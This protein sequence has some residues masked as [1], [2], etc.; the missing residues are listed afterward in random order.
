MAIIPRTNH[1][2]TLENIADLFHHCNQILPNYAVPRFVRIQS[3]MEI[4]STFKQ[5]KVELVKEAFD[6]SKVKNVDLYYANFLN[7][8]YDVL[9]TDIYNTISQGSI[10]L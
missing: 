1:K 5:R 6:P 9:T 8:T 2:V 7:K 10:R 4:T 3:Q